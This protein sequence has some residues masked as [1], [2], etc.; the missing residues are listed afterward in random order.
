LFLNLFPEL[1]QGDKVRQLKATK[2]DKAVITAAV[3]E[4][5]DLKK[6]LEVL[7]KEGPSTASSAAAIDKT[8]TLAA[9]SPSSA[10]LEA[11]TKRVAEQVVTVLRID[12]RFYNFVIFFSR[13]FGTSFYSI[14]K[15]ICL[16][17]FYK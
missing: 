9:T 1:S 11:L 2:A 7:Q 5:L 15:Y 16:F 3:A 17:V 8:T 12:S 10:D 14:N 6:R 4:L 13:W